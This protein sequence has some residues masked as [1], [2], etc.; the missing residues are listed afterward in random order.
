MNP[1]L[2]DTAEIQDFLKEASGYN[3]EEGNPRAKEIVHRIHS[4]LF[5]AI[6]DLNITPD[7][8]WTGIAYLNQLGQS[9]EAA[10]LSP[11]L[12]I[13][14][15]LDMRMDAIDEA[16]GVE[17]GTQRMIEGPLYVAGAPVEKGYARLDDGSDKNGH[18]LLMHG[19]VYGA[20][21]N[22]LPNAQVEVWHANTKGFYSH[23][24]PTGEQQ[25]FNMRRTI[26]TDDQGRYKF[27]SILPAGY[28]CP[29]D[30]P[31]QQLLNQL[32]RHGNRPAHL[33]FFIS[34]DGHRK[35]TTQINID[36]DPYVNDDFAYAVHDDL[37]PPVTE[38]TDEARMKEENME[39]P[40][41]EIEFD[42]RLTALVDGEDNQAVERPRL[43]G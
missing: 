35:L 20:D 29:P 39:A 11:G 15:Y 43:V 36:G 34:A 2:F 28:G 38:V 40:F 37:V 22:P 18:L 23:F 42:I 32:G 26:I 4:G 31:T 9:Q 3:Q 19:V 16:L 1:K 12:G 25:P 6:E 14:R 21:G 5:K 8:Y 27:R 10:L 17:G 13:D 41:A 7:E 30:G 24:D 33:H